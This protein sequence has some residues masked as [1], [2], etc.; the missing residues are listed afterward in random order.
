MPQLTDI[1]LHALTRIMGAL[2]RLY[3]QEPDIYEDFVREICAEFTLAREYMLVI[4]EMAAQNADRQAMA[5]AD[6]T[7]RHLLAL[8]VLTNDLTVP[9]AGADQIRQ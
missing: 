3:L 7:L 1:S 6:L 5:Q 2:D 9:L 8:W 4:Q